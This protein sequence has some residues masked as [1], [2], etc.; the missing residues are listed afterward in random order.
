[1]GRRVPAGAAGLA[2]GARRPAS[3]ESLAVSVSR[4]VVVFYVA[5][6]SLS[7][8]VA[9]LARDGHP[10]THPSPWLALDERTALTASALLGVSFAAAVVASTRVIAARFAWS[11][12]LHAELRPFARHLSAGQIAAVAALG[13]VGEELFFRALLTPLLGVLISSA[14][15][16]LAHQMR[17]ASRWIWASWAA[18]VGLGLG[19]IFALTGSLLGPLLAH[20]AINGLNL[21]FVRDTDPRPRAKKPLGGLFGAARSSLDLGAPT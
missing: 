8:G 13:S 10:F 6:A 3:W 16:G 17:G 18:L 19:S 12:G 14:L 5:L 7:A 21:V 20:A 2:R 4:L 9:A 11:R 15:F 1:M